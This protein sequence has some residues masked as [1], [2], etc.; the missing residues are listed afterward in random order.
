[1]TVESRNTPIRVLFLDHTAKIG[2]GEIA[3]VN[4][5]RN[6]DRDLVEPIVLL[7][8]D[9][10][11]VERLKGHAEIHILPIS[12]SVGSAKKDQLGWRSAF[13]CK[14]AFLTTVHIWK[15]ACFIRRSGVDLVHTNSLKAD[16]IGG[17][18]A[19][20]VGVPVV[21]HVRDRI[22]DDYL[23]APVVRLFRL[24]ASAIPNFII[25]NSWA[26]LAT[27]NLKT[28]PRGV[29]ISSGVVMTDRS[30][31]VHD[32]CEVSDRQSGQQ[33]DELV[34]IGLI[35]RI[36]PWKGQ[37]IFLQAAALLRRN[38]PNTRFEVIG[39]P[40]FSEHEY[41]A[42]LH[43]L[44]KALELEDIVDFA[45][46]VEDVPRRIDR[47]DILVHASTLPEPFGQVIIEAMAAE[48]PVVA[49]EGGGASEIV[50]NGVT[51]L[52]VPM[53][54][55]AKMAEAIG[56][57]IDNPELAASMGRNGRQR[58]IDQFTIQETARMVEAVYREV[59]SAPD[60][61][62]MALGGSAA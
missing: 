48:K 15:V 9:G 53:G 36:S 31:V 19:R 3:L 26:T 23:P 58:V 7:Y 39:A 16:I 30:S 37:H 62:V 18:A 11:L 22:E 50:V 29:A 56:R 59:L 14:A 20:L 5:V 54:D 42:Q 33:Q 25:A 43:E 13:R 44:A 35:G 45:G 12:E 28:G 32:G 41:E 1:M 2:G 4:L 34:R 57:L 51:G 55:A 21:W 40:L 61:A 60:H 47:L 52:L 17:A 46:F 6:L 38:Y 8:A 10:P 49:T 24:L 27:L